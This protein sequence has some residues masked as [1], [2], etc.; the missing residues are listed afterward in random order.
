MDY[1]GREG[2]AGSADGLLKHYLGVYDP[3]TGKLQIMEARRM[4]IRGTVRSHEAPP[5][6]LTEKDISMVCYLGKSPVVAA[7]I[8]PYRETWIFE[9][10]SAK[11]SA[12]RRHE[13]PFLTLRK[14][15]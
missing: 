6:A 1:I 10:N 2:E 8:D 7:L 9:M 15:P 4:Y 12:P 3:S 13:K 5:E 14:T 11:H